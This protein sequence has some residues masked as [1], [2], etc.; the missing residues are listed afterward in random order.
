M[1]RLVVEGEQG[2]SV[3]AIEIERGGPSYTVDTLEAIHADNPAAEL[4]LIVGADIARTLPSWHAP[5]RLLELAHLAVAAR[6]G[7]QRRLVLG[8]LAGI[9]P[10]DGVGFLEMG[11]IEVSSSLARERA[12]RGQPIEELVGPAVAGYI[13]EHRLYRTGIE[14]LR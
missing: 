14:V 2:L 7:S 6:A 10:A 1:C 13:A 4:T 11:P 9:G 8:A 5:A 3:C 12:A